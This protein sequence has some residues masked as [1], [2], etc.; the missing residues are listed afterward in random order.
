[1]QHLYDPKDQV[2]FDHPTGLMWQENGSDRLNYEEAQEY[3]SRLNSD[4][5]AG[6]SDWR[7]PTLEETMSLMEAKQNDDNGLYLNS[8]FNKKQ[9]WVWTADKPSISSAWIVRFDLGFCY[10]GDFLGNYSSAR[11]VRSE[12]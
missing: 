11:A 8:L 1:L 7:L 4:K 6:L 3:I 10:Y 12:H 2:I 9:R 5:F